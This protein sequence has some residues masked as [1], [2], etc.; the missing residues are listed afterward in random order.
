MHQGSMSRSQAKKVFSHWRGTKT[1]RPCSTA[2]I[3]GRASV[4]ASQNHCVVNSGSIGT[5]EPVELGDDR[6][7]GGETILPREVA[8]ESRVRDAWNLG[9]VE[10]DLLGHEGRAP[11]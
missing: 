1:V 10:L 9:E 5:P 11:V 7:A 2:S 6:G 4:A 8:Q 3:A